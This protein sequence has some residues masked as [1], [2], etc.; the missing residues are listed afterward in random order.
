VKDFLFQI[1]QLK[2]DITAGNLAIALLSTMVKNILQNTEMQESHE[3]IATLLPQ[4]NL[5]YLYHQ[6]NM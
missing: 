3:I 4:E 6:D 2:V 1:H 5:C